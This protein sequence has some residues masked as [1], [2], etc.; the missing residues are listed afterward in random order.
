MGIFSVALL[1]CNF[2]V[3]FAPFGGI[4][5]GQLVY[6]PLFKVIAQMD[7]G[8]VMATVMQAATL[9]AKAPGF[10][11]W[12]LSRESHTPELAAAPELTAKS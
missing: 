3:S 12:L 4:G 11:A 9:L 7:M 8:W 5:M 10:I 1:I 2:A 6:G